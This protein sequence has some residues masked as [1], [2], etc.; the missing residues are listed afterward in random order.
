MIDNF[1]ILPEEYFKKVEE[2]K[3]DGFEMMVD[4]TA[5]DWFRK[6]IQGLN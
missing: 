4:L 1:E 2:L 3:Q 5:V 6:K